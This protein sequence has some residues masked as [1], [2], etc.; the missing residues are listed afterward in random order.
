[1]SDAATRKHPHPSHDVPEE[2]E[3]V[4][5]PLDPDEGPAPTHIPDDPELERVVDPDANH[6]RLG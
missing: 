1:M 2:L 6:A 4:T 5:L 3:P